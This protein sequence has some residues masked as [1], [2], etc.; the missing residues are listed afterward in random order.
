MSELSLFFFTGTSLVFVLIL[1]SAC[2]MCGWGCGDSAILDIVH[3]G[4]HPKSEKGIMRTMQ[5]NAFASGAVCLLLACVAMPTLMY[6]PLV[7]DMPDFLFWAV[8]C[9]G[10]FSI[11]CAGYC[12]R[13][14]RAMR[15]MPYSLQ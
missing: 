4:E 12:L 13:F 15:K 11:V 2:F 3:T 1:G 14:M 7:D 6:R 9:P 8:I 10:L 5:C